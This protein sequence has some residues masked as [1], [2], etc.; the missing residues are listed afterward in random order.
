MNKKKSFTYKRS[1]LNICNKEYLGIVKIN[2]HYK[3]SELKYF[4]CK[5]QHYYYNFNMT[6]YFTITNNFI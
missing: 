2:H 6:C 3:S 4:E 1:N 5:E